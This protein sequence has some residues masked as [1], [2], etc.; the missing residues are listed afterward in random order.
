MPWY[1]PRIGVRVSRHSVSRV[2]C[3]SKNSPA[4]N[5]S[6]PRRSAAGAG[7]AHRARTSS[8]TAPPGTRF[9]GRAALRSRLVG[10]GG[11]GVEQLPEAELVLDELAD[12]FV[13]ETVRDVRELVGVAH[14][15]ALADVMSR[16]EEAFGQ[17]VDAGVLEVPVRSG[18]PEQPAVEPDEVRL[19][20]DDLRVLA[21]LTFRLRPLGVRR[22]RGQREFRGVLFAHRR[23]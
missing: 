23:R 4:L 16:R 13:L 14:L 6:M 20:G 12:A 18:L 22:V 11:F 3:W 19:L 7:S 1:R 17:R 8:S 5:C 2:S 15:D 10:S 9:G 21:D